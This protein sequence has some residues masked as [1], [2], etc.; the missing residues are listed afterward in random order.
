MEQQHLDIVR[1]YYRAALAGAD[2][3]EPLTLLGDA[4]G[5]GACIVVTHN[6]RTGVSRIEHASGLE[7]SHI[8]A[9]NAAGAPASVWFRDQ[10]HFQIAP[11]VVSGRDLLTVADLVDSP[12]YRFWL[13]PLG[14]LDHAFIVLQRRRDAMRILQ[15]GREER[16][17]P[18]AEAD[19][20]LL[21]RLAADLHHATLA[22]EDLKRQNATSETLISALKGMPVG[23]VIANAEGAA[24]ATNDVAQS[25]IE[26]GEGIQATANGLSIDSNSRRIKLRDLVAQVTAPGRTA[27]ERTHLMA[28][29]RHGGGRPLALLLTAAGPCETDTELTPEAPAAILYV[30]DPD[31]VMVFDNARIAK[32]YGLSRAESRV[33]ALLASGYRLEQAADMLGVAYETVRKHL[34]QIFS[35]TGTYR[36]A[37]LVRILVNGPASLAI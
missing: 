5:A 10:R 26:A 9:F 22:G 23:V 21:R 17:G 8:A 29:S 30:G 7:A 37:E 13:K 28:V 2:W 36:Q 33:A 15:L 18:F 16:N 32:L 4:T 19:L 24:L 6:F 34:K 25:V 14:L 35:K 3:S 27:A 31:R 12:F 1:A 20:A 11:S